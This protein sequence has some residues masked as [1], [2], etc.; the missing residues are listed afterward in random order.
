[1]DFFGSKASKHAIKS[2]NLSFTVLFSLAWGFNFISLKKLESKNNDKHESVRNIWS[3]KEG[4]S[5]GKTFQTNS[6]SLKLN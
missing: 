6:T 3:L 2:L 1:M 5:W 4:Y